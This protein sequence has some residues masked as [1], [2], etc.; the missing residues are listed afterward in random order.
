M[1]EGGWS[2]IVGVNFL[3]RHLGIG[4]FGL[5]KTESER[6]ALAKIEL[7]ADREKRYNWQ[8]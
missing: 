3:A 2:R 7:S 6:L 5:G 1:L 4:W 8:A